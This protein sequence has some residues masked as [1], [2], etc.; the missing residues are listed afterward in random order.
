MTPL[1][2]QQNP[3]RQRHDL[4]GFWDFCFDPDDAGV[5]RGFA[6]GLGRARA[7]GVRPIAVPGS[8]NEQ[9]E[10]GRDYLGPVWY[11][12]AF[13]LP[14]DWSGRRVLLRF[15]SVNYHAT[16][17]LHSERLGEHEGGHLPFVLDA[18]RAVRS[19]SNRLV[20]RVE[21]ELR[22]DRVPPGNVPRN[23]AD[24]FANSQYPDG[25]FDFFPYAGIQR[26]VVLFT[27][28]DESILDVTAIT[29]RGVG[30]TRLHVAVEA[31]AGGSRV[32]ATLRGF[33]REESVEAVL[34]G[35]RAVL[36]LDVLG[37]RLWS[38]DEPNLHELSVEL[39]K[40]DA[41]RDRVIFDVGLR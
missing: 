3:H 19:E 31:E 39:V 8:Y 28:P 41:V 30:G 7:E 16:V 10:H 29:M 23:P 24:G 13:D 11:E 36:E 18:T 26:P 22:P 20:V 27:L 6:S 12:R 33:E 21:G 2:P 35:G 14:W 40:G 5:A 38:L 37:A 1:Y 17:W 32:R 34:V 9:F 4:S 25:A 15:A